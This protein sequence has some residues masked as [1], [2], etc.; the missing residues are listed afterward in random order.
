MK[1]D[2]R[3]GRA[4]LDASKLSLRE[5]L[6]KGLG[7]MNLIAFGLLALALLAGLFKHH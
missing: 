3:V 6:G 7:A 4:G 2:E 5:R 1:P